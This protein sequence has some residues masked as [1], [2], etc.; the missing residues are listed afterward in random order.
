[1]AKA[2]ASSST[3]KKTEPHVEIE[4]H[5]C[6]I[7]GVAPKDGDFRAFICPT[8]GRRG[9]DVCCILAGN[10]TECIQCEDL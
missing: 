1:M 6:G 5:P 10:N 4:F 7:C 8:C 9:Y 2:P 3:K